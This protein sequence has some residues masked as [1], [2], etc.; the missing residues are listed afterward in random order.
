MTP[1]DQILEM[2]QLQ[3]SMNAIVNPA[4]RQ[5]GY[6]WHRAIYVE[7]AELL[8]HLGTWKWWKKGSPDLVQAQIELVD[9]WHFAMS[10]M[11]TDDRLGQYALGQLAEFITVEL[12]AVHK[13]IEEREAPANE[14]EINSWVDRLVGIAAAGRFDLQ[15]FGHLLHFLQLDLNKLH[16]LY[17]GKNALNRFRQSHGYKDGS[18]QKTWNGEEDNVHLERILASKP[19]AVD[20]LFDWVLKELKAA[21]PGK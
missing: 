12:D 5:A 20:S 6:A 15:A 2:L 9:I 21:Y 16:A 11:M 18:Y 13:L 7:G 3:N 19:A 10:A 8:D 4:W 17:V 14:E 1:H